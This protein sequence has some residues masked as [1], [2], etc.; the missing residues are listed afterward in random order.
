MLRTTLVSALLLAATPAF[1]GPKVTVCH[2]AG[3]SGNVLS[4]DVSA[5]AL[6]AH[7][8]HGDWLPQLWFADADGDGV[9]DANDPG[10]LA[11]V[12]PAGTSAT[13]DDCDDTND[14][15][16]P[17]AEELCDDGIDNDCDGEVDEGC[18]VD[19][20]VTMH[21]DNAWWLWIDGVVYDGP[22]SSSW[23]PSDTVTVAL[24]PGDHS[25]A[26]Y[27]EDWGG[28]AWLAA[29]VKVDGQ[30]VSAT[31]DGSWWTDGVRHAAPVGNSYV[32]GWNWSAGPADGETGLLVTPPAGWHLPSYDDSA[33][34]PATQCT[35]R[36]DQRMSVFSAITHPDWDSFDALYADGAEF[37]WTQANC[38]P[39][40]RYGWNIGL[41]R[42]VFSL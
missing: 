32:R 24:P 10:V 42:T 6:S 3:N 13:G 21:A 14:T 11:C 31:G 16:Y 7:L 8:G 23:M 39:G 35:Y 19:V 4:L 18:L 41:F 1:A 28:R 2:P 17:G 26:V 27:V 30:V 40:T 34:T 20:E 29:T 25:I 22:N 9:G 12:Q 5:N 38:Y 15:V 33:W 36:T 37:V